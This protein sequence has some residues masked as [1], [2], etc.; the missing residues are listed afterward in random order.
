MG[1]GAMIYIPRFLKTGSDIEKL[2]E[3]G[4]GMHKAIFL[5]FFKTIKVG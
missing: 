2:M 5:F 1:S 3:G 4:R